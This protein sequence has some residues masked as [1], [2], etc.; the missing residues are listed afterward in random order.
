MGEVVLYMNIATLNDLN[1]D[2]FP[3]KI[4]IYPPRPAPHGFGL[5]LNPVPGLELRRHQRSSSMESYH[6]PRF[7]NGLVF[8]TDTSIGYGYG[9]NGGEGG[10][11][12]RGSVWSS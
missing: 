9:K 3:H 4:T 5:N 11:N 12:M 10:I 2:L 1:I 8:L 6:L 7:T